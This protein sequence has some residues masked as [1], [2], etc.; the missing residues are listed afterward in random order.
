MFATWQHAA[1]TRWIKV[2]CLKMPPLETINF[3]LF[4]KI[5]SL[6]P[7]IYV[8]VFSR[9]YCCAFSEWLTYKYF[10]IFQKP[11]CLFFIHDS[12][13]CHIS[14]FSFMKQGLWQLLLGRKIWNNLKQAR[15]TFIISGL[16]FLLKSHRNSSLNLE[17]LH[18]SRF[19][20]DFLSDFIIF[21]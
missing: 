6:M 12:N 21:T 4:L 18:G 11:R 9:S 7:Y 19:L 15:A 20:S 2:F 16:Q 17:R 5:N 1:L 8:L 13:L 14:L 3:W 10:K